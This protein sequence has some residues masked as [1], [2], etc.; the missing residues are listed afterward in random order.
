M[1]M[2]KLNHTETHKI[3]KN[4]VHL[5]TQKSDLNIHLVKCCYSN[6]Y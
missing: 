4:E 2:S 6:I 3:L 1:T 5:S